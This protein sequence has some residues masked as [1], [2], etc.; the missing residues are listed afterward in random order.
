MKPIL[1]ALLI[2]GST[3]TLAQESAAQVTDEQIA[4]YQLGLE[5]ACMKTGQRRGDSEERAVAYC[6]CV[7]KTLR[8]SATRGEWQQA[9]YYFSKRMDREEVQALAA[10]TP[11]FKACR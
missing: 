7:M 10:Y 9:Y 3:G 8:D 5:I 4:D 1:I 2:V 6:G 11:K